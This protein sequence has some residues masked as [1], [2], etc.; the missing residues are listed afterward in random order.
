MNANK[1]A[2]YQNGWA[3]TKGRKKAA[4]SDASISKLSLRVYL[5]LTTHSFFFKKKPPQIRTFRS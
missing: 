3:V 2:V 4:L 1:H 5:L